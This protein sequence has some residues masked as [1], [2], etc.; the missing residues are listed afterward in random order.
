VSG[1]EAQTQ[2]QDAALV[3]RI[4]SGDQ[5]AMT[6]LY[7][8]YSSLVYSVALRVVADTGAAEDIL[9]DVFLQL[10]RKP[11]A[12]DAARGRLAPWLA[13]IARHRAIDHIRGRKEQTDIEDVVIAVDARL[14]ELADRNK[15]GEKVRSLLAAMPAEQRR[16]LEMSFFQ[17]LT[18]TEIAQQTGDPLGTVKTRIRSGLMQ[19]RKAFQA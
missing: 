7:D 9:Q 15:A 2:A 10:W 4:R 18:H 14:E 5:A 1:A 3:A 17:G 13:V 11:G 16:A 8:R 6:E 12:F 19:L